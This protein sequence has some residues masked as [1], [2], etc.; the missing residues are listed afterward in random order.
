MR[1][2]SCRKRYINV[3]QFFFLCFP[4]R[5]SY[6]DYCRSRPGLRSCI[7]SSAFRHT[8]R[9]GL[10]GGHVIKPAN[11]TLEMAFCGNSLWLCS[12]GKYVRH[13]SVTRKGIPLLGVETRKIDSEYL[14]QKYCVRSTI[15]PAC[16]SVSPPL[17][18]LVVVSSRHTSGSR[19]KGMFSGA[20][21]PPL[22]DQR[23][24]QGSKGRTIKRYSARRTR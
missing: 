19:A 1:P 11:C 5:T 4:K 21:S 24:E 20:L 8:V 6:P 18:A 22:W 2:R 17:A 12:Q 10:Y 7:G 3:L 14:L 16:L 9:V 23:G 13:L 15:K